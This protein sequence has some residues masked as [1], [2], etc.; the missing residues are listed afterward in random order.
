MSAHRR[1]TRQHRPTERALEFKSRVL[2]SMHS[3]FPSVSDTIAVQWELTTGTVWWRA[4]VLQVHSDS[5]ANC[6][7]GQILYDSYGQ[8]NREYAEVVFSFSKK[9]SRLVSVIRPDNRTEHSCSWIFYSELEDL[10]QQSVSP[11]VIQQRSEAPSTDK[12]GSH[13][14][15]YVRR[16]TGS[17]PRRSQRQPSSAADSDRHVNHVRK[18]IDKPGNRR[19]LSTSQVT[20]T[21]SDNDDDCDFQIESRSIPSQPGRLLE[22]PMNSRA[23]GSTSYKADSNNN[24]HDPLHNASTRRKELYDDDFNDPDLPRDD[25]RPK[26]KQL[27]SQVQSDAKLK[28]PSNSDGDKDALISTLQSQV[29][30]LTTSLSRLQDHNPVPGTPTSLPHYAVSVL[31]TLKWLLMKKLEKPLRTLPLPQLSERGVASLVLSVKSDCDY[32]TFKHIAASLQRQFCPELGRNTDQ[33]P[34][35]SR[36]TFHPNFARTQCDST[37]VDNLSVSFTC[38]ADLMDALR[39]RDEDDFENLLSMEV[40]KQHDNLFQLIGTLVLPD[41]AIVGAAQER[42]GTYSV[43]DEI[44]DENELIRTTPLHEQPLTVTSTTP[45]TVTT[46]P[47][48]MSI[49]IGTSPLHGDN[50]TDIYNGLSVLSDIKS[51]DNPFH[52]LAF[53]QDCSHFCELQKC[54]KSQWKSVSRPSTLSVPIRRGLRKDP[55][56]Q[57]FFVLNWTQHKTPST[58]KWSRDAQFF[59]TQSPGRLELT[60]PV[61]YT[62]AKSNASALSHLMDENIEGILRQRIC[63]Q[64][65]KVPPQPSTH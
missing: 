38:F 22:S 11:S 32:G 30:N 28:S 7:R 56:K 17:G 39:V 55:D 54:Y 1:S 35:S 47:G 13:V 36:I 10:L 3:N 2:D 62:S 45:A 60:V 51:V 53:Q 59:G 52:T 33:S 46:N 65:F 8:Y 6:R 14:T 5:Q 25:D 26:S 29:S 27:R 61:V 4:Q 64:Q 57:R 48:T 21:R 19:R 49:Y 12:R 41:A 9:S 20:L 15:K 43:D 58:S 40:G 44:V 34:S 18:T 24:G 23:D 42:S 16:H 37:G 31:V 50:D 63:L